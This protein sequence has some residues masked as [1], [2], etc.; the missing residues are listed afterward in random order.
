LFAVTPKP[1][2]TMTVGGFTALSSV[3][4]T[5]WPAAGPQAAA[6]AVRKTWVDTP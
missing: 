2:W 4:S 5:S 1:A 3:P 6:G